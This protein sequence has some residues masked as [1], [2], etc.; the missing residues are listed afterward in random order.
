[1]NFSEKIN[2]MGGFIRLRDLIDPLSQM[3][4]KCSLLALIHSNNPMLPLQAMLSSEQ[5]SEGFLDL[6][7]DEVRII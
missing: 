5:P 6:I 7:L 3:S 2:I 4:L 1:M